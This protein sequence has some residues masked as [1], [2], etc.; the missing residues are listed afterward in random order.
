MITSD[1][2]RTHN[3]KHRIVTAKAIF[4][5]KLFSAANRA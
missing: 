4:N 3:I 2:K 1:A 5:K